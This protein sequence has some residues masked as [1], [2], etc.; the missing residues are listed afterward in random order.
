MTFGIV[1]GTDVYEIACKGM[2]KNQ[3]LS[4]HLHNKLIHKIMIIFKR[5]ADI[6]KFLA[7]S[8]ESGKGLG[9][10]PTMGALHYGHVSLISKSKE[11]ADVTVCSIFVNPTQFN[12]PDDLKNYPVKIEDDIYLLEKKGCD[13]LFLPGIEELYPEGARKESNFDLGYLESILE[14]TYRPGHFQGVCQVVKRLLDIVQP[15]ILLLG[16]KDY[17]QCMVIKKLADIIGIST[18]ILICPTVREASGLAM[19][20]RNLRLSSAEKI[21]AAE[22]YNCLIMIRNEFQTNS[23]KILKNKATEYLLSKGFKVD[24]IEIANAN[25]LQPATED[26]KNISLVT[27]VAAYINNIRLIDNTVLA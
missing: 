11:V 18:Q 20:S 14:G 26:D 10:V 21:Q 16:Q 12:N 19:S 17:Q 8:R 15:D 6:V 3:I 27:L 25:T 1:N 23:L 22:I 2:K 7:K 5:V 4:L 24:Y 13:V 9:L